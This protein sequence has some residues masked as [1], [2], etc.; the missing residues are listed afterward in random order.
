MRLKKMMLVSAI[1]LIVV[2][3][4]NC[5]NEKTTA[6]S[7]SYAGYESEVKWGEHLITVG[8]CGDCHTPKKMGP[9]GPED[10]SSM[11]LSGHPAQMPLPEIDRGML[12]SKGM[13]ATQTLTFWIGPWGVSYAA[14]LTPDST[15]LLAWTEEQFTNALKHGLSKGIK[16][17]RMLL[18]PMPVQVTR[19][20]KDEEIKAMFAYLKTIK[21]IKNAVPQPLPP[22]SPPPPPSQ[23]K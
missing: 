6:N 17:N 15:G 16:G 1:A 8:G 11:M 14:N 21:P 19:H 13:A 18:P 12:E 22:V 23:E 9:M 4:T 10:D 5:T 7:P 20:L 2:F 3:F